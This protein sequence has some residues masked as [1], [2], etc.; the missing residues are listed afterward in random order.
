MRFLPSGHPEW[1]GIAFA[2][3]ANTVRS[4]SFDEDMTGLYQ[5][6]YASNRVHAAWAAVAPGI[7]MLI[8]NVYNLPGALSDPGKFETNNNM[9]QQLCHFISQF[10]EVPVAV[11]GDFQAPPTSYGA[12]SHACSHGEF[13]DVIASDVN[14]VEDRPTTFCRDKDWAK[15]DHTSSIDCVLVNRVAFECVHSFAVRKVMGLQHAVIQVIFEWP[16]SLAQQKPRKWVPH[17]A[18]SLGN[19]V[20]VDQRQDI[21]DQLWTNKYAEQCECCNDTETMATLANDFCVE[22]LLQSG[23]SWLAGTRKRGTVPLF[24]P[25]A[26]SVGPF[27]CDQPTREINAFS[28]ALTR[29][30]DLSFKI[31]HPQP[32]EHCAK[33]ASTIWAKISRFLKAQNFGPVPPWPTQDDLCAYWHFLSQKRDALVKATRYQRSQAWK[34]NM[35]SSA[36]GTFKDVFSF[37]KRKDR[38]PTHNVVTDEN[39]KPFFNPQEVLD[40]AR[41]QWNPI[42]TSHSQPI[43]EEPLLNAIGHI[44]SQDRHEFVFPPLEDIDL[45]Q[46]VQDRKS[47]AAGGIDGWRTPELQALPPNAFKP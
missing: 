30:D 34:N 12:I 28:K 44:V 35:A 8:V 19:L 17:A 3:K 20:P 41:K 45:Y 18:L 16:R 22:I 6:L 10:G 5:G 38:P 26:K 37:L 46:A 27:S 36:M 33:I 1:G 42:F 23:A 9:F 25:C 11:V 47:T 31:S 40:L 21:A 29:L 4:I 32:T 39:G 43:P 24:Q 15:L 13:F 7:H 14:Q 2:A